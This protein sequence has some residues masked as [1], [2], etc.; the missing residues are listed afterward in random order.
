M[1][2]E[3]VE[4]INK[5]LVNLFGYDTVSSQVIWRVSW[6][7]DQFEYRL[8]TYDDIT[9]AGLYLRTVTEVRYVPKYRQW[10]DH[11]YIL[12]RLVGIPEQN[13]PELPAVKMSYEVIWVFQD[14]YSN[15]LPP[16]IE[17]CQFIINTIY[18]AQYGTKNLKKYHDPESSQEAELETRKKRVD[19]IIEELFGEQSSLQ[20]TTKTGE[21]IIVPRNYEKVN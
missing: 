21:S 10:I 15:P 20:G 12:E 1:E 19:G 3:S 11:K 9:S 7:E 8:G 2:S 16:K 6:S 5:Q 4:E 14:K 13:L 18:A 17:A